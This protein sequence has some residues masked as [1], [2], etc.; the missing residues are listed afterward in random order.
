M[1]KPIDKERLTQ[2]GKY[3]LEGLTESEAAIMSDAKV[4]DL[5]AL[6]EKNEEVRDFIDKSK[7]QFKYSHIHEIQTKKSDKA[8]QW[9]LE[10]LRPEDFATGRS[11]V[12][13]NINVIATIIKQIQQ[14]DTIQLITRNRQD[15]FESGIESDTDNRPKPGFIEILQP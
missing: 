3:I 8:S 7:I 5:Q 4:E 14:D 2:I 6:K 1:S 12:T 15:R 11:K 9:L 13:N 10:R